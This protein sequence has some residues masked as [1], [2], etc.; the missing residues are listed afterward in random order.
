MQ[1]IEIHSSEMAR[2]LL[3]L[4]MLAVPLSLWLAALNGWWLGAMAWIASLG[5][6]WR[7]TIGLGAAHLNLQHR[8]T[9]GWE[10]SS[11][12]VESASL[13]R[14]RP[15]VVGPRLVIAELETEAQHYALV[16]AADAGSPEDLRRLRQLLL[17]GLSPATPPDDGGQSEGRG[18]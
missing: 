9:G 16:V 11:T 1:T 15:V 4:L 8:P 7:G 18:T 2:R 6:A 13:T 3:V 5:W 10:V 14:V 12:K 17:S